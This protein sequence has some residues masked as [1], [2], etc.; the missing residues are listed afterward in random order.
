MPTPSRK[1]CVI[2]GSRAEYGLLYWLLKNMQDDPDIDLQIIATGMHLSPEFGKTVETIIQD[3]FNVSAEVETLLSSDSAVGVAKS[4]GLGVLG[5]ADAL[6]SLKPDLVLILGDRFEIFAAAQAALFLRIPIAHIAGGDL[7]YG[8]FDEALR[9]SISKMSHL[10][11]VTNDDAAKRLAR[12][13]ENPDYIFN[14]GNPGLDFMDRT[15]LMDRASLEDS[16]QCRFQDKN[17]LVTFHPVTLEHTSSDVQLDAL[18]TALEQQT[19]NTTIIITLPNADTGGRAI[20]EKIKTFAQDKENVYSYTSLGQKRYLSMLALAD[21]VIG[22]SS[23]G[24]YEAPSFNT[25][26]VNIGSRQ[27]GRLRAESVFDCPADQQA[28]CQ[29][30]DQ[31]LQFG[32]QGVLNPYKKGNSA[33]LIVQKIK[34]IRNLEDLILKQ[35]YDAGCS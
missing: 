19:G 1:I 14:V 21:V 10:H 35:F 28:I 22:N 6:N 30:I 34:D 5:F 12:M 33:D 32:K 17:F 27:D 3:G 25:P 7:T 31:A 2:T 11:F 26:T 9:H 16:M 18:L 24:L 13:G 29:T 20:I 15:S 23:S 8:A 4:T